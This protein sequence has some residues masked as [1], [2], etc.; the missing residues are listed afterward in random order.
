[1]KKSIVRFE[2]VAVVALALFCGALNFGVPATAQE[3]S[4]EK[5]VGK[6]TPT[7]QQ[8]PTRSPTITPTPTSTPTPVPIQTITELQSKIR[9][10]LARPELRRGSVGVKIV[11]LD[12]NRTIFEENAAKYFMLSLIH[13]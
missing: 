1:M 7:P 5:V 10:T 3:T 4:R 9:L 11:S 8:T 2:F 12:T 6:P 13:I